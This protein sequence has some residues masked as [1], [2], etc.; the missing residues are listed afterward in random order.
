MNQVTYLGNVISA[1]G[2]RLDPKKI[3]AIAQMPRPKD[4][5]QVRS[6]LGLINHYG[7]FVPKMR[8]LR[9]PLDALLKKG[10]S[11]EWNSECETAL[12]RAREVI[13]SD[14]L[15]T[16]YDYD[17]KLPIILAADASDYGIGVVIS[18]RY[19]DGTINGFYLVAV[20]ELEASPRSLKGKARRTL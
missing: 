17:P 6:F 13:T 1:A 7:A 19:P 12:E 15:L 3:D 16:R 20:Y 5:A 11:F 18:H 14:L 8:Q 4:A 2:R 9:A 10:A